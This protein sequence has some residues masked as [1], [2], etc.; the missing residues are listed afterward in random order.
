LSN[1]S[2]TERGELVEE[3]LALG[4][5]PEQLDVSDHRPDKD[6]LDRPVAEYLIR[7]AEIAT[8]RV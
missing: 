4:Q 3:G 8:R 2:P 1:K 7:Q 6:E 5:G